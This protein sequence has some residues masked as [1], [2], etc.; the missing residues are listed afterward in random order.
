M[1]SVPIP[2]LMDQQRATRSGMR[3]VV[4]EPSAEYR[5]EL[6]ARLEQVPGFRFVGDSRTWEECR[7]LLDA[8]LPELLITRTTCVPQRSRTLVAESEFP[9]VMG[10]SSKQGEALA[11]AFETIELPDGYRLLA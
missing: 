11:G 3:V 5:D 7:S 4:L 10:L 9:V 8:Y 2:Y 6:R 1:G